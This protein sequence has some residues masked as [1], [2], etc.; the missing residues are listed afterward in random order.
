M[1]E[2]ES[3]SRRRS[4]RLTLQIGVL[5]RARMAD[6]MPVQAQA[7][8]SVVN[9]HG[10]LLELPIKL[11]NRQRIQVINPQSGKEVGCTVIH[12]EGP[13]AAAYELAFEF[14]QPSPSFWQIDFAPE[15]W[16]ANKAAA[17]K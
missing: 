5:I 12:V 1:G 7:F 16:S 11:E 10:G 9:A 3:S 17:R 6:G 2:L 15:D 14:D 13:R 4:Q 8:T